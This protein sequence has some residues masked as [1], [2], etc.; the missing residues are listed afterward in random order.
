VTTRQQFIEQINAADVS[1]ARLALLAVQILKGDHQAAQNATSAGL[2]QLA[3]LVS[4]AR[5]AGC[6][7]SL[8]RLVTYVGSDRGYVGNS[9]DYYSIDNSDLSFVLERRSGIPI[10]LAIIYIEIGKALGFDLRGIGFPGHFLVGHYVTE[11][12]VPAGGA[13]T[14]LIDPYSGKLTA[15]ANCLATLARNSVSAESAGTGGNDWPESQI[16]AWFQPASAQQ[17]ALRLLENLKQIYL[18]TQDHGQALAA[19]DLQLLVAPEQFELLR[20]Q[21]VLSAQ[22][23]GR[24]DRP[25]VH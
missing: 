19:L 9:E 21:Q 15:R 1:L 7:E 6:E 22:I 5:L 18:Q 8:E 25:P 10:T 20:Q 24:E 2:S 13:E 4:D 16:D 17:I 14:G 11:P 3:T 23:F 12:G